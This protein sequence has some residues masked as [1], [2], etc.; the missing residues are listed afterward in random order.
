MNILIYGAGNVGSQ[1]ACSILHGDQKHTIY[2]K[3]RNQEKQKAIVEDLSDMAFLLNRTVKEAENCYD[4]YDYIIIAAGIPQ[5]KGQKRKE[6]F[7]YNYS[8]IYSFL[9]GIKD[10]SGSVL[11]VTNPCDLLCQ[12]M[13]ARFKDMH[14][15][16]A[17]VEIDK[18]RLRRIY[19]QPADIIG[20]HDDD[21]QVV[22]NGR[23]NNELTKKVINLPYEIIRGKG[24]TCFG[25]AE[26][27]KNLLE[28]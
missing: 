23:I 3:D 16:S 25:I 18:V 6:L 24:N 12:S 17:G 9:D 1:I 10:F 13:A 4:E 28:L 11:I 15:I 26:V 2:I 8:I 7:E 14:I 22:T 20:T 21:L 27:V 19:D 5:R